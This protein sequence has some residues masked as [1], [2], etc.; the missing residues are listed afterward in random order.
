MLKARGANEGIRSAGKRAA[1]RGFL[2]RNV[3]LVRKDPG[4]KRLPCHTDDDD[5]R[6]TLKA[7]GT[8]LQPKRSR[9][10]SHRARNENDGEWQPKRRSKRLLSEQDKA[11]QQ[12]R[13]EGHYLQDTDLRKRQRL[14]EESDAGQYE[15]QIVTEQ[16]RPDVQE[17][18]G[19]AKVVTRRRLRHRTEIAKATTSTLDQTQAGPPSRQGRL[20][21]I[22]FPAAAKS[23]P[24][25]TRLRTGSLSDDED[26]SDDPFSFPPP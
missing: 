10:R 20:V 25:A 23:H 16:M 17:R 19:Q 26:L 18:Q 9:K 13:P 21:E 11:A 3:R 5:I 12:S 1:E 2:E 15:Y 14:G 22:R 6:A 8:P 4:V 7:T 24:G